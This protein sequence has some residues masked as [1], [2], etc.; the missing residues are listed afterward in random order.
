MLI[1]MILAICLMALVSSKKESLAVAIFG[2]ASLLFAMLDIITAIPGESYYLIAAAVDCWA[3]YAIASRCKFSFVSAILLVALMT[4]IGINF[5][6]LV[7]YA[8][9]QSP[10]FYNDAFLNYYSL[11]LLLLIARSLQNGRR[12]HSKHFGLFGNN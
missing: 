11:V 9:Y 6:G 12:I 10:A 7:I 2:G 1:A 4:S 8:N 3:M 5:L